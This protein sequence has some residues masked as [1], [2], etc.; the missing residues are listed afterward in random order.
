LNVLEL[1]SL[2]TT[3][4]L[5]GIRIPRGEFERILTCKWIMGYTVYQPPLKS[6]VLFKECVRIKSNGMAAVRKP[7]KSSVLNSILNGNYIY[8]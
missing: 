8:L 4:S 6:K 1:P 3:T 7:N 2:G 5:N